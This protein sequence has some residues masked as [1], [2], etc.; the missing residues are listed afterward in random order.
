MR[1]ISFLFVFTVFVFTAFP[2]LVSAQ[3]QEQVGCHCPYCALMNPPAANPPIDTS[4]D[5]VK[6]DLNIP[7]KKI[8][9]L[10]PKSTD[11]VSASRWS[12]GCEVLDR[13]YTDYHSYKEYLKPLG[14]KKLRFQS[15]WAKTEKKKGEYD[16]AWLDAIVNDAHARG[17]QPWMQTSYGNPIY[18]QGGGANLGDGV[19]SSE[20][21]LAAWDRWV[22]TMVLRYKDKVIEWEMWNEANLNKGNTPEMFAEFNIRTAKVIK[23]AQPEAIIAG[24]NLAGT[25]SDYAGK[26]FKRIADENA[27]DLFS[28]FTY[29]PYAPNPDSTWA[30][31]LKLQETLRQYHP[32]IPLRQGENGC[33]S[34]FNITHALQGHYWTE[35][36]QAKWF[37]R[38]NIGDLG[39]GQETNVFA[40]IDM[41]YHPEVTTYGLLKSDRSKKVLG[42]KKAYYAVQNAVS[43]LDDRMVPIPHANIKVTADHRRASAYAFRDTETEGRLAAVWFNSAIPSDV[44]ELRPAKIEIVKGKFKD[45]VYVDLLT[46]GVYEIPAKQWSDDGE[47]QVF[48]NIPV[49]DSPILLVDRPLVFVGSQLKTTIEAVTGLLPNMDGTIKDVVFQSGKPFCV[50]FTVQNTGSTA[51][52]N[53]LLQLSIPPEYESSTSSVRSNG[54]YNRQNK[55]VELTAGTI[56]AGDEIR[57]Q[58]L[59]PTITLQGYEFTGRV[60]ADGKEIEK[61]TQRIVPPK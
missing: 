38:R 46:G 48:E 57:I 33:P 4:P 18:P 22:E 42:I 13:D 7:L 6:V 43:M 39:H 47:L 49:Y 61:Q 55:M 37:L 60:F 1:N 25:G 54:K 26:F 56:P 36:S 45:P 8:G 28:S 27:F 30:S 41:C 24:L 51:V 19:P 17:L 58:V 12:L 14:I 29:H 11:E 20:E 44:N 23:K 35:L 50:G 3:E 15:G 10:K 32:T 16:W 34:S 52:N 9:T 40:I 59:L 5:R 53:V 31:T 21:A 2:L